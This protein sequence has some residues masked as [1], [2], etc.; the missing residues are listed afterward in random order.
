IASP[1]CPHCVPHR[2]PIMSLIVSPIVFPIHP[3][4]L[5]ARGDQPATL[6]CRADG[7]PTPTVTWYRDGQPVG[8]SRDDAGSPRMLLPGGSLVFLRLKQGT[9]EGIYTCVATNR[10]G[11]ATSRNATVS[12]AGKSI[13]E[14]PSKEGHPRM[15]PIQ[16]DHPRGPA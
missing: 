2:V 9:D 8:T 6:R 14:G 1:K 5:A 11:T 7:V 16:R 15:A 13:Q 10:L 12:V 4:D 3:S